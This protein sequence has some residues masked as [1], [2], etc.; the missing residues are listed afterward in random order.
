MDGNK[1][2]SC[3]I[4]DELQSLQLKEY[5]LN[6]NKDTYKLTIEVFSEPSILF[7]LKQT[8]L[9]SDIYYQKKYKYQEILNIMKI[10]SQLYDDIKKISNFWDMA[11]TRKIVNLQEERPNKRMLLKFT[12]EIYFQK[13]ETI[14]ELIEHQNKSNELMKIILNE[15]NNLKNNP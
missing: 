6:L 12:T 10:S 3:K 8:N 4:N 11:I 7:T 15:I 9:I 2:I 13:I 14:I 1:S 5:E